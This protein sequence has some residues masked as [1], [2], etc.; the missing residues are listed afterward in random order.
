[1][2][3][4]DDNGQV[5]IDAVKRNDGGGDVNQV[6]LI[7]SVSS[8]SL[9][10]RQTRVIRISELI[11]QISFYLL[12]DRIMFKKI[13]SSLLIGTWVNHLCLM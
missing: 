2:D 7:Q 13:A 11:N 3:N 8:E 4:N 9:Q 12:W 1:M 5:T 10:F 6:S